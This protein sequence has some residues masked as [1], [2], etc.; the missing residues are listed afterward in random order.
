[1]TPDETRALNAMTKADFDLTQSQFRVLLALFCA[2]V[3]HGS[4]PIRPRAII[5][6]LV[7]VEGE[8]PCM[9]NE[10]VDMARM[11]LVEQDRSQG[12][13]YGWRL[14]RRGADRLRDGGVRRLPPLPEAKAS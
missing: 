10:L 12:L 14:T 13:P 1:M 11:G 4:A 6:I 2:Q 9:N 5:D 7:K 8:A 3:E